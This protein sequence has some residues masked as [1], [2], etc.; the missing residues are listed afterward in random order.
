ML[1]RRTPMKRTPF[2][3]KLSTV[4]E[5]QPNREQRLAACA[6][7]AMKNAVPRAATVAGAFAATEL[8]VQMPMPFDVW[9]TLPVDPETGEIMGAPA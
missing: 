4:A 3:R 7:A 2:G 8:G 5:S 1:T 6:V 9:D